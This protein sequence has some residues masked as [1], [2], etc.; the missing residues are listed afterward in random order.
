[1]LEV[2]GILFLLPIRF[3]PVAVWGN[4]NIGSDV[5][6]VVSGGKATV[7][8]TVREPVAA[9]PIKSSQLAPA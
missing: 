3:E 5:W 2:G 7:D 4:S 1:V 9:M 8:D 6:I